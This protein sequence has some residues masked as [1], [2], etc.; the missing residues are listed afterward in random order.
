MAT[1]YETEPSGIRA[2][3]IFCLLEVHRKDIEAVLP[4]LERVG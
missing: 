2:R 3:Q 1:V 4:P